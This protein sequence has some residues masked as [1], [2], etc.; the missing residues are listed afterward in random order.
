MPTTTSA[1]IGCVLGDQLVE[2]GY[3]PDTFRETTEPQPGS[4]LV[5]E[6]H[7][8]VTLSPVA[9]HKDHSFAAYSADQLSPSFRGKRL[10]ATQQISALVVRHPMSATSGPREP[11]GVRSRNQHSRRVQYSPAGNS[12]TTPCQKHQQK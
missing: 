6:I 11:A 1:R 5:H 4:P 7:I 2:P 10:A 9:T 3:A 12:T 8:V